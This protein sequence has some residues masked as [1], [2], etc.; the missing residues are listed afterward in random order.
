MNKRIKS[1]I[2]ALVIAGTI[3]TIMPTMAK[4]A[5]T[6]C[7]ASVNQQTLLKDIGA[8]YPQLKDLKI[9]TSKK[10][11][12]NNTTCAAKLPANT[13]K[14][15]AS[16]K[17]NTT[18]V[19]PAQNSGQASTISTEANEVIK[20]VNV[21][22]S[23]NGLTPL[24]ANAELSK[25]ATAKA[26][27]MID[28]NYFSHTSPTYG[29]PFDMM[30]KFGISYTAAGEN[31]AYGQKTPAEVMNAWMNSSGHR[32]NILN[33]NFTEIGVGVAKDKNGTPYWVQMFINPG[34]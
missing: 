8:K 32:A 30:K 33:S 9:V 19:K 31:I 22:R 21:E 26:Q 11:A 4:A 20:L 23:K 18:P 17:S 13:T 1:I 10:A 3:P 29:S 12:G 2:A 6:A 25:V 27:D 15:A 28:K 5:G 14:P 24:K 7:P 34:K 16:T